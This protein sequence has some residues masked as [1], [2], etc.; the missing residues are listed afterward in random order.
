MPRSSSDLPDRMG[1][2]AW[3]AEQLAGELNLSPPHLFR[4]LRGLVTLGI[5]Q[6]LPDGSFALAPGGWSLRSGSQSRLDK[7]VQIVVEQH[8]QP[9]SDLLS[10][11][12]TGQPAF[13]HVFGM[14]VMRMAEPA[15]GARR[16]V[17]I[18]LDRG[19]VRSGRP[20]RRGFRVRLKRGERGRNRRRRGGMLA[21]LLIAYPCLDG[22]LFDRPHV[23][24]MA[25]LF[26]HAFDA[27]RLTERIEFVPGDLFAVI[28]IEADLYLLKDVLQQWPDQAALAILTN[29]RNAMSGGARL[30]IIERLMPERASDDPSAVMVDLHMMTITGGRARSLAAF[31]ALLAASRS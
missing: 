5:C 12:K 11:L 24:E 27:F 1:E 3:T 21:A 20:D 28:P 23:I 26:L 16:S 22:A 9:W 14:S 2:H 31:E 8:W 13:D 4:F 25:K 30:A 19:D 29:C 10:C 6:E 7:K 17:R 18:L 15:Q